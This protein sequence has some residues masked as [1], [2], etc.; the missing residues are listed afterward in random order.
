MTKYCFSASLDFSIANFIAGSFNTQIPLSV[1]AL[2][3]KESTLVEFMRY[4]VERIRVNK[5]TRS[6]KNWNQRELLH[7][8]TK[9][10]WDEA[11]KF[12]QHLVSKYNNVFVTEGK[13]FTSEEFYKKLKYD[14]YQHSFLFDNNLNT[15]NNTQLINFLDRIISIRN[16]N[17]HNVEGLIEHV[18]LMSL[19]S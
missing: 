4:G 14:E 5:K 8:I 2:K 6:N 13:N 15:S 19:I 3:H 10:E 12:V 11:Q 9:Q 16:A 1:E 18:M 7:T 17:T